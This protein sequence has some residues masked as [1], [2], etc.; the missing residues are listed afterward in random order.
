MFMLLR[1][2]EGK[3]ETDALK[4]ET[5]SRLVFNSIARLSRLSDE[6]ILPAR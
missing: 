3:T 1:S 5:L 6:S 2:G 4:R